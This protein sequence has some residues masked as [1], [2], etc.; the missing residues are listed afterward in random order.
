MY[1]SYKSSARFATRRFVA[2]IPGPP[3]FTEMMKQWINRQSDFEYLL[4]LEVSCLGRFQDIDLWTQFIAVS[5]SASEV[6]HLH[7][8]RQAARKR[9]ALPCLYLYPGRSPSSISAS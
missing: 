1:G 6:G 5:K 9:P 4:C 3:V 2:L 7:C 8:H